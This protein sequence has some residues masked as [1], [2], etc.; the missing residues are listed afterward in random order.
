MKGA[1]CRVRRRGNETQ[2]SRTRREEKRHHARR[3]H[4]TPR[5]RYGGAA[6]CGVIPAIPTPYHRQVGTT[7]INTIIIII[8]HPSI[9]RPI[10]HFSSSSS[11]SSSPTSGCGTT[12][13]SPSLCPA[14][15]SHDAP[16]IA[17]L[18][19]QATSALGFDERTFSALGGQ[20]PNWTLRFASL[21]PSTM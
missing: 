1:A 18:P 19:G 7:T 14:A 9:P 3:R 2:M 12:W 6:L 16:S 8:T 4:A 5:S 20:D 11:S 10:R 17:L 13:R 21:H 15:I